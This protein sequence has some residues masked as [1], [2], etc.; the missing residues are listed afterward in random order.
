MLAKPDM[1]ESEEFRMKFAR[2]P[3]ALQVSDIVYAVG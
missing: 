3:K 2:I 1:W